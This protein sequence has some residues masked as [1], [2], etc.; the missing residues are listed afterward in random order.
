MGMRGDGAKASDKNTPSKTPLKKLDSGTTKT[1]IPWVGGKGAKVKLEVFSDFGCPF[2]KVGAETVHKLLARYGKK[3]KVFFYQTPIP[4][5][6]PDSFMASQA[7]LAA[8]AQGKFWPMH[9][10]LYA[11]R[12]AHSRTD[13][14]GYARSLGLDVNR[15]KKELDSGKYAERVR[16]EMAIGSKRGVKGTP[17]FFV[18]GQKIAGAA[19]LS[20]FMKLIDAHL[21]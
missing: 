14:L 3:I 1:G 12:R 15:F 17:T 10:L 19:P 9:D 21:D 4:S 11:N 8:Q 16:R 6:H 7:A 13:L 18:N 2:C 5:L 20:T